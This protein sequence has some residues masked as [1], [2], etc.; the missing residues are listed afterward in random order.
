ME[1][2]RRENGLL[3]TSNRASTTVSV[4]C[5]GICIQVYPTGTGARVATTIGW[6]ESLSR[7]CG[8]G[9]RADLDVAAGDAIKERRLLRAV[10]ACCADRVEHRTAHYYERWS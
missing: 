6:V 1:A 4:T 8:G 7:L 2:E 10:V 9:R 3:R 5:M